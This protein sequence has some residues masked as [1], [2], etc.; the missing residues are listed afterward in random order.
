MPLAAVNCWPPTLMAV[1]N[2][3]A[4]PVD[5]TWISSNAAWNVFWLPSPAFVDHSPTANPLRWPCTVYWPL[6]AERIEVP[7]RLI[8]VPVSVV[9]PFAPA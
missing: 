3:S 6:I 5:V 7:A 9:G 2:V 4:G 1:T 8:G